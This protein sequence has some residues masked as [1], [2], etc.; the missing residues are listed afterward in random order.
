MREHIE[1]DKTHRRQCDR[2]AA[3]IHYSAQADVAEL[4]KALKA[5]HAAETSLAYGPNYWRPLKTAT[6][7]AEAVIARIEGKA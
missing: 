6:E 1:R 4:M 7:Q 3:A 2:D 5:L